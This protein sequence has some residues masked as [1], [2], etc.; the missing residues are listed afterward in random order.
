MAGLSSI[1]K[2]GAP[3]IGALA[4]LTHSDDAEAMFLGKFA[5]KANHAALEVAERMT[6]A[7]YDPKKIFKDTGWFHDPLDN[8]WKWELPDSNARWAGGDEGYNYL[9][10]YEVDPFDETDSWDAT[11]G[12]A[13]DHQELYDNYPFLADLN[14]KKESKGNTLGHFWEDEID[15]NM[16]RTP[17]EARSTMLH[18]LQHA[19]QEAEGFAPGANPNWFDYTEANELV[20]ELRR[21]KRQANRVSDQAKRHKQEWYR[22]DAFE[23]NPDGSLVDVLDDDGNFVRVKKVGTDEEIDRAKRAHEFWDKRANSIL[24]EF[25]EIYQDRY[26]PLT[27]HGTYERAGGEAE[28][29]NVQWRDQLDQEIIPGWKEKGYEAGNQTLRDIFPLDWYEGMDRYADAS[30]Q[31]SHYSKNSK[32]GGY[33]SPYGSV[34]KELADIA[35]HGTM[36]GPAHP[37]VNKVAQFFGSVGRKFENHPLGLVLPG[38][39]TA[40]WLGKLSYQ[41]T[42]TWEDRLGALM[43]WL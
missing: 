39:G 2:L 41:Q 12:E 6:E 19:I 13:F 26:K 14:L 29:R 22:L 27:P 35:R 18:E 16:S 32:T 36:K 30:A 38:E 33:K 9:R 43:D 1:A 4:G 34:A 8:Q 28:S 42:P 17:K 25:D 24:E 20:P 10:D 23:R 3:A 21:L 37:N 15:I 11:V 5:K 7:G 40:N 31:K